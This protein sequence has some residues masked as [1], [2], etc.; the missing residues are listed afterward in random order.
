LRIL[1]TD[2][3]KWSISSAKLFQYLKKKKYL[4]TSGFIFYKLYILFNRVVFFRCVM[5]QR[6]K[7]GISIN[8]VDKELNNEKLYR[9]RFE[10]L[11]KKHG[12]MSNVKMGRSGGGGQYVGKS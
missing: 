12:E 11:P 2:Q 6:V 9:K 4:L 7:R 1:P 5:L 3:S 10:P 8:L